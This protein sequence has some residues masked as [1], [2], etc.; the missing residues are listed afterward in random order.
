[1]RKTIPVSLLVGKEVLLVR[2]SWNPRRGTWEI[3]ELD[4]QVLFPFSE[5]VCWLRGHHKL[6]SVEVRAAL[7]AQAL[8][9]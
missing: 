9:R 6:N 3:K 7:A 4:Y 2:A 8:L 5:N 1:M